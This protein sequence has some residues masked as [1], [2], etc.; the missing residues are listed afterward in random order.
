MRAPLSR[1][2]PSADTRP[3]GIAR[4]VAEIT[5]SRRGLTSIVDHGRSHTRRRADGPPGRR[6]L[7][8]ARIV[9]DTVRRQAMGKKKID[10]PYVKWKRG[11]AVGCT[12]ARFLAGNPDEYKQHKEEISDSAPVDIAAKIDGLVGRLVADDTVVAATLVVPAVKLLSALVEV[13]MALQSTPCWKVTRTVLSNAPCG[14]VVAFGMSRDV[15]LADGTIV[16]SE[17]LVLGPFS[18]FPATRRSPLTAFEIFVGTPPALDRH[19]RPTKKANLDLVSVTPPLSQAAHDNMWDQTIAL[20]LKQLDGIDDCR[21]KAKVAFA[22]PM[23]LAEQLGC[24]L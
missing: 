12:F 16:P 20:R 3:P 15:A 4:P 11:P 6:R 7:G 22:I 18:D 1:S 24:V 17:A 2:Q 13:A 9:S 8:I 5:G 23:A 21:A 19:S 14:P 10:D